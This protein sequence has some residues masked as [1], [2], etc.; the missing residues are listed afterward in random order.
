[1]SI[2]IRL[3]EPAAEAAYNRGSG[4]LDPA[5][6]PDPL[7]RFVIETEDPEEIEALRH[8]RRAMLREEWTRGRDGE[9]PSLQDAIFSSGDILWNVRGDQ[10]PRCL[11][12]VAELT[13]RTN[14]TLQ[15]LV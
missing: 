10:L 8:A 1:M 12:K 11:E 14:R 5:G 2:P 9:E 6:V 13:E 4:A 3:L 7:L 15:Q